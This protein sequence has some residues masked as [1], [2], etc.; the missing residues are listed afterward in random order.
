MKTDKEILIIKNLSDNASDQEKIELANWLKEDPA[1]EEELNNLKK[2]WATSRD[3][4]IQR[5]YDVDNAWDDFKVLAGTKPLPVKQKKAFNS[6]Q[7]AAAIG[8]VIVFAILIKFFFIN[9]PNTLTNIKAENQIIQKESTSEVAFLTISTSDSSHIFTLPDSSRIYLNTN[10]KLTYPEYFSNKE[11][12]VSLSG[13]A[14]FE[15]IHTGSPFIVECKEIRTKVLGTSFN[16]KGY[17]QDEKLIVSVVTGSV[18]LIN[19]AQEHLTLK[20]NE[21]GTFNNLGSTFTKTNYTDKSFIW[22]K[23][24]NLRTRIKKIIKKIKQKMN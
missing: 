5:E 16:V 8:S 14:F 24:I 20:A 4:K 18:E 19:D 22:W 1:N 2:I 3:L 15:V 12:I 7:I 21:R 13:E 6:L 11:R 17:D 9:K 10:S 23:K